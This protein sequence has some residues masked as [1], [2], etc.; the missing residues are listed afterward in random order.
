VLKPNQRSA[1]SAFGGHFAL[2]SHGLAVRQLRARSARSG[3]GGA[4]WS[5]LQPCFARLKRISEA[6]RL[7]SQG[8][9]ARAKRAKATSDSFAEFGLLIINEPYA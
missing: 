8:C 2:L 5:A 4:A 3:C 6:R 1:Q 9:K 7:A